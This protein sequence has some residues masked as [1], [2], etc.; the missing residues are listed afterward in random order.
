[1]KA[2]DQMNMILFG[3]VGMYRNLSLFPYSFNVYCLGM[4]NIWVW[5]KE[6]S[7]IFNSIVWLPKVLRSALILYV[8]LYC[9]PSRASTRKQ[10]PRGNAIIAIITWANVTLIY[11]YL[12]LKINYKKSVFSLLFNWLIGS[13]E[14]MSVVKG[15]EVVWERGA[16]YNKKLFFV[17]S[18]QFFYEKTRLSRSTARQKFYCVFFRSP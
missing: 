7:Y 3:R 6:M 17:L 14:K 15:E 16:F 11:R 5:L 1:M 10:L 4:N 2:C 12:R 13:S 9:P 18:W 8:L